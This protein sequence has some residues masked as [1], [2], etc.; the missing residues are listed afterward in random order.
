MRAQYCNYSIHCHDRATTVSEERR[1]CGA[2]NGCGS[3]VGGYAPS[4]DHG[5][6]LC[7]HGG[8]VEEGDD[9]WARALGEHICAGNVAQPVTGTWGELTGGAESQQAQGTRLLARSAGTQVEPLTGRPGQGGTIHGLATRRATWVVMGSWAT[10][11]K[12]EVAR[13]AARA[14]AHLLVF[15]FLKSPLPFPLGLNSNLPQNQNK[16]ISSICIIQR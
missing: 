9:R 3:Q 15:P 2:N 4:H 5:G 14:R 13:W 11:G 16:I 1:W 12:A 8:C 7:S 10:E 6:E